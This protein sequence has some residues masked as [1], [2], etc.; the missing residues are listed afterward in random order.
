VGLDIV[1]GFLIAWAVA[2]ARRVAQRADGVIDTALD[3]GVDRV[4][5]MVTAKL[6]GEPA[7][8]RLQIE[9]A[10]SGEVSEST[11]TQVSSA[12]EDAVDR[13]PEFAERLRVAMKQAEASAVRTEVQ[14]VS[15]SVSG[16]V[17]GSNIQVGGSIG[18][19]IQV[20]GPNVPPR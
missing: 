4:R 2:K 1:V 20:H 7:L 17:S 13:D 6:A 8:E 5:E 10:E 18:G 9:A 14:D 15:Q 3:A 12:L 16:T 11:R 19:G